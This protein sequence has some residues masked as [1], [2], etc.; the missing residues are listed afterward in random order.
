MGFHSNNVIT[1]PSSNTLTEY[2]SNGNNLLMIA[3]IIE[4]CNLRK[5][6]IETIDEKMEPT[7]FNQSSS[8]IDRCIERIMEYQQPSNHQLLVDS[9][10]KGS[11]KINRKNF[12]LKYL[13]I[14]KANE[15]YIDQQT[16]TTITPSQSQVNQFIS[17]VGG[18][19]LV[20]VAPRTT[21]I[22]TTPATAE[23]KEEGKITKTKTNKRKSS[24]KSDNNSNGGDALEKRGKRGGK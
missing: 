9:V 7:E 3:P 5:I 8:T 15:C 17:V 21:P 18:S 16:A 23:V 10:V 13:D 4:R 14:R 6:K 11:L 12:N 24:N 22:I 20:V 2:D 1:P 19:P